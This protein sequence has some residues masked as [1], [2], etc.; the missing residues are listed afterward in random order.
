MCTF[1]EAV[2]MKKQYCVRCDQSTGRQ[3][4]NAIYVTAE[5]KDTLGPICEEC[6]LILKAEFDAVIVPKPEN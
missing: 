6:L 1:F 3:E 4:D 5:D 2:K